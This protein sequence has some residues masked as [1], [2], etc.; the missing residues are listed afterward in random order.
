VKTFTLG[1]V[2]RWVEWCPNKALS[3]LAVAYDSVVVLLNPGVG[4]KLIVDKT[5]ALLT[6]SPEQNGSPPERVAAVAQWEPV[7]TEKWD[8]GIRILIRHFKTVRQV[9]MQ[10]H[11]YCHTCFVLVSI[12]LIFLSRDSNPEASIYELVRKAIA[13]KKFPYT[14]LNLGMKYRDIYYLFKKCNY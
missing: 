8:S 3:L 9:S 11:I 10:S 7:D 1:G 2:V 5:D 12:P 13:Q 14:F 4:D 6:E